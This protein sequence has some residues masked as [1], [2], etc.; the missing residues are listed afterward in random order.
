MEETERVAA[1]V[2]VKEFTEE[3]FL[4][5]CTKGGT[6]KRTAL[7]KYAN[8][9]QTGIIG[10]AIDEGDELLAARIVSAGQHVILAT[11]SGKSIRFDVNDVRPMGRDSRGGRASSSDDG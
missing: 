3:G 2:P 9:R 7:S 10:V 5:T 6:V 1:V 11:A 4:L 8:I